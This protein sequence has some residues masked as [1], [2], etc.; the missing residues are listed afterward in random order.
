MDAIEKVDNNTSDVLSGAAAPEASNSN[1]PQACSP[2]LTWAN[3]AALFA[4]SIT[5][6]NANAMVTMLSVIA[7]SIEAISKDMA[8]V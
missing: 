8:H 2:A 1:H 7:T 4:R 6:T 5:A 3:L